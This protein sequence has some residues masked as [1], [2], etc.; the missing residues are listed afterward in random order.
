[1]PKHLEIWM[2]WE[3]VNIP[4]RDRLLF[5]KYSLVKVGSALLIFNNKVE[6]NDKS[7]K[8]LKSME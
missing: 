8:Y 6:K 1:M 2:Y 3:V 5:I 7:F 4:M